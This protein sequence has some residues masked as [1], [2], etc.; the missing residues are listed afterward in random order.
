[1]ATLVFLVLA[2]NVYCKTKRVHALYLLKYGNMHGMHDNLDVLFNSASL[3]LIA[4]VKHDFGTSIM[5]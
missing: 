2:T 4:S 5:Q 1:M 3:I